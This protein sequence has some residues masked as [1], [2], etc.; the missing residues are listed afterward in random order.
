MTPLEREAEDDRAAAAKRRAKAQPRPKRVNIPPK[1]YGPEMPATL[2][3]RK[4]VEGLEQNQKLNLCCRHV[5]ESGHVAQWAS[6]PT[7]EKTK[8][9]KIIP[10]LLFIHCGVCKRKHTRFF[11]GSGPRRLVNVVS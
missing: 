1:L 6:T 4:Y 7:A 11:V 3:D 2:L 5:A 9:G 10:D 8:D